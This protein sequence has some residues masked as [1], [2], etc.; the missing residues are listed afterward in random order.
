M[1]MAVGAAETQVDQDR[2]AE[3]VVVVEPQCF[4]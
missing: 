3:A 2:P 4:L 1:A